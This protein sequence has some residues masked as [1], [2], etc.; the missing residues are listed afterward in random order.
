MSDSIAEESELTCTTCGT[1]M[2]LHGK[3]CGKARAK[4]AVG[5][6]AKPRVLPKVLRLH[7]ARVEA[8]VAMISAIPGIGPVR[9]QAI[10]DRYSTFTALRGAPACEIAKVTI[11]KSPLGHE[12]AAAVCRCVR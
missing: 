12:L 9:A 11:K 2:K 1:V 4:K 8:R 6:A 7:S 5:T 10:V 3:M